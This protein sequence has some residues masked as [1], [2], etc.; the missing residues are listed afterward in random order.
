MKA[1]EAIA[2]K[3]LTKRFLNIRQATC[4][5]CEPLNREDYTIQPAV[6]ASPSKWHL[7]HTTWFFEKMI[8]E[9]YLP[10]Y[11][12]YDTAFSFLFN[13]Y[14]N[15][16]GDRVARADR[17]MISRPSIEEVYAYRE[18]VDQNIKKLLLMTPIITELNSLIELGLQHEQQH[19]ELLLTDIKY[20]LNKNPLLPIYKTNGSLIRQHNSS[21]NVVRLEEGVYEIGSNGK[22]FCFDNELGNHKVYLN[23]A[24]IDDFLVTNG[25]YIEFIESGGYKQFSLWLDEGWSHIQKEQI[26]KPLYWEKRN[27]HWFQFTLSGLEIIDPNE[28]L[29]HVSYYEANAFATWKQKRLLTEFEWEAVSDRIEWGNRWEWTNSAYLPYPKFKIADGA[30]GEYNGKFMINQMVL[31]GASVATS[32]NHSRKT[33]RNF[34]HPHLNWQFTGIRL[35]R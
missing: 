9:K 7:A 14:Y 4:A 27:G 19:Q 12:P 34:F 8:L 21:K 35:A 32:K 18:Y 11:A 25:E 23:E 3:S 31:R 5:L 15:S 2:E 10:K 24:E 29:S 6:F 20:T 26:D 16:L 30:V 17:G 1:R 28:I 33:Y 22:G 13:S